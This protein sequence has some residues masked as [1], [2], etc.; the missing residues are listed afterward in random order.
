M[1]HYIYSLLLITIQVKYLIV[2]MNVQ[3]INK[4]EVYIACNLNFNLL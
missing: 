1:L 3:V 4:T 2:F